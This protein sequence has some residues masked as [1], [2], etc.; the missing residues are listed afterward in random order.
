M[1]RRSTS[2]DLRTAATVAA[3]A[4]ASGP[5]PASGVADEPRNPLARPAR[6]ELEVEYPPHD[7]VV[8]GSAC[9]VFVAGRALR[10]SG[11][12]PRLDVALVLDTSLSTAETS[13][14]D[15]NANGRVGTRQLGFIGPNPGE[16]GSDPGDSILAAEVAAARLLLHG[17]DPRRSR[18]AV[19]TFPGDSDAG[20]AIVVEP[21]TSDHA[22]IDRALRSVLER[23]PSGATPIALGLD[24]ATRELTAAPEAPDHEKVVVFFTDGQP[25]LPFG[26]ASAR[27]SVLSVMHAAERAARESIRIHSFA[28]G[29]EALE[30]PVA[31]VEMAQ[32][33]GGTFTPVPRPG[34]LVE[35][36]GDVRFTGLSEVRLVNASTDSRAEPF[37]V[38]A[39]GSWIGFLVMAPG[40]NWIKVDARSGPTEHAVRG[41]VVWR[42]PALPRSATLPEYVVQRN[43][44]LEIC[45]ERKRRR[46]EQLEGE[47]IQH[48]RRELRLEIERARAQARRRA[49]AQRKELNLSWEPEGTP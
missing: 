1:T 33:T 13:G 28:V 26:P 27:K 41:I 31:V 47:H 9:G 38:A 24:R 7:S 49:A 6:I 23:T 40:I 44:L 15:I 14:V 22:R 12:T 16:S 20:D 43:E 32:R 34:D 11:E 5:L 10:V 2:T 35:L 3:I 29:R 25:T 46:R 45:L 37:R 48:V 17:L 42:D 8:N 18:L 36:M 30:G 19:L 4:L 21:L 39:D